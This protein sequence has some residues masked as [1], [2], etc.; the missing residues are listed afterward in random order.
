MPR[1]TKLAR[2]EAATGGDKGRTGGPRN[3]VADDRLGREA[4]GSGRRAGPR[5]EGR[6]TGPSPQG[7]HPGFGAAYWAARFQSAV[8]NWRTEV[9][10]DVIGQLIEATRLDEALACEGV[11]ERAKDN[12]VARERI[13]ARVF[14]HRRA[15]EDLT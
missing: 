9:L 3:T 10:E 15:L 1:K 14:L 7:E 2:Q 13:A 12:H 4:D 6:A 8:E 5:G 11:L